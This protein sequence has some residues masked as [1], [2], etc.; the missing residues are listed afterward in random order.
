VK[1]V[2]YT[3]YAFVVGRGYDRHGE[4]AGYH[5]SSYVVLPCAADVME[6]KTGD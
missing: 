5:F 6:E 2:W 4:Y 3:L 1:V